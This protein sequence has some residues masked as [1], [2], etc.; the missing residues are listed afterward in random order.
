MLSNR[1]N[2]RRV[3]NFLK[4]FLYYI[5]Q[6]MI[7][8]A[9]SNGLLDRLR[10]TIGI[11]QLQCDTSCYFFLLPQFEGNALSHLRQLRV[12]DIHINGILLECM[13]N[14]DG[15]FFLERYHR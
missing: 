14:G 7:R 8:I 1:I 5:Q 11:T 6:N 13:F 3:N 2:S 9:I 4:Q 10:I 12:K 15:F